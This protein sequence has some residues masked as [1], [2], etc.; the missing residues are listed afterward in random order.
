ML[1]KH[2]VDKE[3]AICKVKAAIAMGSLEQYIAK[4]L[5]ISIE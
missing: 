1:S 4:M 3:N 2:C 5:N